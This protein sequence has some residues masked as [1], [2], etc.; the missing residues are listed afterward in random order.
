MPDTPDE[1]NTNYD[2][3]LRILQI[4]VNKSAN[5]QLTLLNDDLPMAWDVVLL[6]EPS[7]N[8]YDHILTPRGFRQ[9]Y[10]GTS[11][12]AKG[13]VRSGIWVNENI[14]TDTWDELDLGDA[15]DITGIQM[16][17]EYGR[18]TIFSIYYDCTNNGTEEVLRKYTNDHEQEIYGDG[19]HV[20]WAGDFNQHHPMWDDD[21]DTRLFTRSA[22]DDAET[23]I[24]LAA[25]WD[26]EQVLEKGIPT[27]EH[28]VTKLWTRPDNVWL[29]AHSTS[30]L[31]KCDTR[32]ELRPPMTGHVPIATILDMEMIRAPEIEYKNFR[33]TDWE[34]FSDALELELNN[35]DATHL[36]TNE[37]E[38]DDR[39]NRIV[40]AIQAVIEKTVPTSRPKT[41]TRRWWN[42][43]L[44]RMRKKKQT[45]SRTHAKYRDL[46]EHPA[47]QEY[48]DQQ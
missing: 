2:K 16:N 27:L 1:N 22:L 34:E 39:V 45:L 30:M 15:L 10:P 32:H 23:L 13:T 26:M 46:T 7:I 47:H 42:K 3:R 5:A 20:M 28:N 38:F 21:K 40:K 33:G 35:I 25:E 36:I 4:N 19:G 43:G 18:L 8:Y 37:Q 29:S 24:E 12:R 9:V 17:G 41:Y 6:Q 14:S 31:I 48:R 11:A 44:E